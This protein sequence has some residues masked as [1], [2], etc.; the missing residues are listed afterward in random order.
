MT[1]DDKTEDTTSG[2]DADETQANEPETEAAS[3]AESSAE[4]P[5]EPPAEPPT[6]A[7]EPPTEAVETATEATPAAAAAATTPGGRPRRR[8]GEA[9]EEA[10]PEERGAALEA[11]RGRAAR[12]QGSSSC[13][14]RR[15]RSGRATRSSTPTAT[16][17]RWRRW[18]GTSTSRRRSRPVRSAR[19]SRRSTCRARSAASCRAG[20][21]LGDTIASQAQGYAVDIT[22]KLLASSQ[23]QAIWDGMNRRAHAVDAVLKDQ[24]GGAVG[25]AKVK[26]G[27]ITLD[28]SA[29]IDQV[30]TSDRQ[31]AHLR[32]ERC[33]RS[34]APSR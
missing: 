21:F 17:T 11:C 15:W 31:G 2:A 22:E 20:E 9:R 32:R 16:S 23:F 18:P 14:C 30:K 3:P 19:H 33:R 24:N 29:V 34:S 27:K 1:D 8:A 7:V 13:R 28:L 6:E 12:H 10:A 5:T 25:P 4:P 26:D